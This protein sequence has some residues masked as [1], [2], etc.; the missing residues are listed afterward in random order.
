MTSA[1]DMF[2]SRLCYSYNARLKYSVTTLTCHK[3]STVVP[4]RNYC[5][6]KLLHCVCLNVMIKRNVNKQPLV[7][8]H[9]IALYWRW[10]WK[11]RSKHGAAENARKALGCIMTPVAPATAAMLSADT[12]SRCESPHIYPRP[13]FYWLGR[14][15][16]H[17]NKPTQNTHTHTQTKK[18]FSYC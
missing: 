15:L 1:Y 3:L 8:M 9:V 7:V 18:W 5:A 4:S 11:A 14:V 10:H 17:F 16:E 6:H 2:S 12:R 13:T